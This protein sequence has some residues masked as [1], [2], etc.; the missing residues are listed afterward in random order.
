MKIQFCISLQTRN[1]KLNPEKVEEWK[2]A[3]SD[4]WKD[5]HFFIE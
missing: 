3:S 2:C 5:I 1:N 4:V